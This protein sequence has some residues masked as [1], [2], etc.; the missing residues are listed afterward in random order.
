MDIRIRDTEA[1]DEQPH[2]LWDTIWV[3]RLDASGGHGDW[4]LSGDGDQSASRGGLRSEAALHTATLLIL[5]TDARAPD[6]V[7]LP[8]DDGDRR[9]WWGDGLRLEGEPDMPLGSLIWLEVERGVL[10]EPT[11][12]RVQLAAEEALAV[13][14]DQGAVA[15]TEIETGID[16]RR[17]MLWLLVSHF[18]HDG[19]R[20][21]EQR[22]GV[23]WRQTL[24]PARMT[25]GDAFAGTIA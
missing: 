19:A 20:V 13:L 15:R 1:C 5:F 17:S 25:Y 2:L 6:D 12:A 3:Q 4:I 24:Q 14:A 8:T 11:R 21:Y 9:G 23:L 10:T 18:A 7:A 22:F 16:D